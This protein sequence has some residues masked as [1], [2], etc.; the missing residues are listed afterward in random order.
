M[1]WYSAYCFEVHQLFIEL[2]HVRSSVFLFPDN[3]LS[4]ISMDYTKL[5]MC[6]DNIKIWFGI[7]KWAHFII[8]LNSYLSAI[9]PSVRFATIS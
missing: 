4:K 1:R 3:N 9:R 2:F 6:L 7:A 5:G 8:F